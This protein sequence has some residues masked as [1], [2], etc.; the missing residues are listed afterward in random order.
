MQILH[1]LNSENKCNQM[2]ALILITSR[3]TDKDIKLMP[4]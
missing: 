3:G 2:D 1:L 4:H